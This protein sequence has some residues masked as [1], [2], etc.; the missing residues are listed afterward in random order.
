MTEPSIDSVVWTEEKKSDLA[1]KTARFVMD[2]QT[3]A[4]VQPINKL[5]EF[6]FH[7][8]DTKTDYTLLIQKAQEIFEK[9][10]AGDTGDEA[11]PVTR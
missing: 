2:M 1:E 3:Q 8:P 11:T 9:V 5:L 7:D 10:A 6:T 4:Q